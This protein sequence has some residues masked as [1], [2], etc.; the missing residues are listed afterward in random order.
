M[1]IALLRAVGPAGRVTSYE[2]RPD[3][4]AEAR[5]NVATVQGVAD[6][7]SVTVADGCRGVGE[8]IADAIVIDVPDPVPVLGPAAT[9]VRPGGVV[10][11]YVPTALQLK[12]VRDAL[13][14][15]PSFALAETVE[16][17][18]RPWHADARS[19]RPSHRMVAHTAFLTFAR[20]TASRPHA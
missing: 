18:E 14:D 2:I 6:N 12:E 7:W 3:F 4:A 1:S 17:L 20:R 19:L 15:D 5:R 13:A 16:I 11:V 8:S 9:A 10:A